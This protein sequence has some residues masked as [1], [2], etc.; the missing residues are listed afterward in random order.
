MDP[1]PEETIITSSF[2]MTPVQKGFQEKKSSSLSCLAALPTND[3]MG[4]FK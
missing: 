1:K 2:V 4:L 3:I